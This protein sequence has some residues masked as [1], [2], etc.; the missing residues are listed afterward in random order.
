VASELERLVVR[1]RHVA[2]MLSALL[3]GTHAT[4]ILRDPDGNVVLHREGR[5]TA[6]PLLGPFPIVGD[7]RTIGT[8]EGGHLSRSVAAVLSYAVSRELD[9]R[10]LAR[11]ALDRYRELNLIYELAASLGAELNVEAIARSAAGEASR[12][13][14]GGTGFVL[15]LDEATGTLAPPEGQAGPFDSARIGEGI[16][17]RVA[18]SGLAELVNVP[19][20]DDGATPAERSFAALLCAPMQ[21]HERTVGILGTASLDRVEYRAGD[22]KVIEAIAALAAPAIDHA[23]VHEAAVHELE[24]LRRGEG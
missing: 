24:E 2:P 19:A 10:A 18:A 7:G 12:I 21:A 6:D 9:K 22:L 3:A 17:G 1:H 23:Q 5:E 13:P 14:A 4:I 15:L 20:T 8:V 11:E 16:L